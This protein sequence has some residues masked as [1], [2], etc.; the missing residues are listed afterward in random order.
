[1][2]DEAIL[3]ELA[4]TAAALLE[5]HLKASKEWFPHTLV[6]WERGVEMNED[7][8][9]DPNAFPL[10]DAVR[11]ALFVNLLTEDNL[12]YYHA[13]IARILGRKNEAWLEW[14]H[15][16][17]AEEDRHAMVIRD[18]LTVT[19]AI[20]PFALE[21]ARMVQMSNAVVPEPP[22]A[23][24]TIAY[25]SMQ[26]LATRI[27]HRNTG[28]LVEDPA[29]YA[30][31]ARVATDENHHFLFYRDMF[32]ALLEVDPSTGVLALERQVRDFEMPGTG[33]PDFKA[34]AFA[35]A[36]AGIYDL[37]LHHDQILQPVVMRHYRLADL[38]GLSPEAEE[39]RARLIQ[40]IERIGKAARRVSERRAHE[41]ETA[42]R[43][44]ESVS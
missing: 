38:E 16:W 8:E 26:E 15:R 39:S 37:P 36:Q 29:G 32:S 4:P 41:S 9:W 11:S 3:N 40:R 22:T 20:D 7:D 21:R 13:H 33:I 25:V 34:H 31:M 28:K 23:A 24:D 1:M 43:Q 5:R 35:I 2:N 10:P 18:Y 6:P 14:N 19:Q 12:P 27:S 30:V 42:D 44:T 17:T